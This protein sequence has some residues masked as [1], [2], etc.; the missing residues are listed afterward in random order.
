MG[1][2]APNE[3]SFSNKIIRQNL[4]SLRFFCNSHNFS[5]TEPILVS[6]FLIDSASDLFVP[7]RR[8][9][10]CETSSS[11]RKTG[12]CVF[13]CLRKTPIFNGSYLKNRSERKF[14]KTDI[15]NSYTKTQCRE[16]DMLVFVEILWGSPWGF[17]WGSPR[18]F[19]GDGD[20][21]F[22]PTATLFGGPL[23]YPKRGGAP[24]KCKAITPGVL[25]FVIAYCWWSDAKNTWREWDVCHSGM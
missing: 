3:W 19:G 20:P 21:N 24:I 13:V 10:K 2:K 16:V 17:P 15:D 6:F 11:Y 1:P 25:W 7:F 4:P 5:Q 22:I 12:F 14:L 23:P 9:E 8:P 18:S